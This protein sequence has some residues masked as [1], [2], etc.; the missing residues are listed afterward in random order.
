MSDPLFRKATPHADGFRDVDPLLL[1]EHLSGIHV[2]DVREPSEFGAELGHIAGAHL[3]P[4]ATI[5]VEA[6]T[7]DPTK[8]I[9]LVCRSGG[10]SGR[11]A[12]ELVQMGFTKVLNLRGG[13]IAWNE[14]ARPITR[15]PATPNDV[16]RRD[17]AASGGAS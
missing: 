17:Y 7:W 5:P 15:S 12:R 3:V 14:A 4:L 9:V 2:V 8:T 10:R 13:M 11:A 6:R 16:L 1:A